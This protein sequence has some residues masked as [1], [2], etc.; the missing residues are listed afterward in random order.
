MLRGM[1]LDNLG[2]LVVTGYTLSPN[3][4]VTTDAL[5]GVYGGGGDAFVTVVNALT[6]TTFL[7]YSGQFWGGSDG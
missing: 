3:F 5:Q 1:A 6:P 2:N 7:K 4:P